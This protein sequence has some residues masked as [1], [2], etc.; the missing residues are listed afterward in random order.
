MTNLARHVLVSSAARKAPLIN[1]AI[2][3]ARRIGPDVQVI[4][5][6]TDPMA[7]TGAI[8]HRFWQMPP[9][10]D[11]NLDAIIDGCLQRGIAAILP[12][13]DGELAFWARHRQ[14]FRDQ[15]IHPIV[16]DGAG[17]DRCIDKLA[18]GEFGQQAGLPILP[19]SLT[20]N[21][22]DAARLVVKER[23]G[24][25]SAS[26]GIDLGYAEAIEHAKSLRSPLFQEYTRGPE[27]SIDAWVNDEGA[28]IGVVLRRRDRVISGE[29]AITTTFRDE[30]LEEQA[31]AVFGAFGL[32]GPVMLQAIVSEQ[33]GLRVIE[34]NPRFGGASTASLHVGLDALFWSFTRAL[35]LAEGDPDFVRS[36]QDI[37]LVRLPEDIVLHDPYF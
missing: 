30:G 16:S 34:I 20:P 24:A 11:T 35:G 29:A 7:P 18:F 17:I 9:T 8:A 12:T 23:F 3:A 2:N 5:G 15:G 1:A 31:R 6:D 27:I 32:F 14:V 21:G 4:A 22:I 26:I 10:T 13:R 19:C 28:P 37:Q 36:P 33:K 25:G